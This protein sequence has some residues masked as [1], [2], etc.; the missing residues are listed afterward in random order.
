MLMSHYT[1]R[2]GF[3]WRVRASDISLWARITKLF[4]KKQ[5]TSLSYPAEWLLD[6]FKG[7]VCKAHSFA[8]LEPGVKFTAYKNEKGEFWI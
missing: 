2:W 3:V 4:R 7:G 6:I 1:Y 8:C 5:Q